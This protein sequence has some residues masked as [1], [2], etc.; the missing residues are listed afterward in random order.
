MAWKRHIGLGLT[1]KALHASSHEEETGKEKPSY[2]KPPERP[3]REN[4]IHGPGT[5]AHTEESEVRPRHV[6]GAD[7]PR[8]G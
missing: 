7:K 6:P 5:G 4:E 8:R 3:N 1:D 2:S